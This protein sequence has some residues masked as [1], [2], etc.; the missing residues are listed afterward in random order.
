MTT[1][2]SVKALEL[3]ERTYFNMTLDEPIHTY[4]ANNQGTSI[5]LPDDL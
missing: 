3:K 5:K 2:D 4:I 1:I